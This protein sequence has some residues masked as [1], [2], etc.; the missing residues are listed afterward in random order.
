LAKDL[1]FLTIELL[2]VTQIT[3]RETATTSLGQ[4]LQRQQR[5]SAVLLPVIV[6]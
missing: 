1:L 3:I 4:T 6:L 5:C 2:D